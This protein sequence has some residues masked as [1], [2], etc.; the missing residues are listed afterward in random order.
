MDA[1]WRPNGRPVSTVALNFSAALDDI[2]NLGTSAELAMTVEQKKSEVKSREQQLED[3]DARLRQ[4]DEQ[5]KRLQSKHKRMQSENILSSRPY[6]RRRGQQS[7]SSDSEG[8]FSDG[9]SSPPSDAAG[10]R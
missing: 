10:R 3:L 8:A 4:A 5:L 1:E 9:H 2:F 6:D 7:N